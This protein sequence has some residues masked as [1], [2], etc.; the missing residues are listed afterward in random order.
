MNELHRSLTNTS[1]KSRK[2]VQDGQNSMGLQNY[3]SKEQNKMIKIDKFKL[4][5]LNIL[6]IFLFQR[7]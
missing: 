2:L 3:E 1:D 4:N 6:P 7:V 5:L